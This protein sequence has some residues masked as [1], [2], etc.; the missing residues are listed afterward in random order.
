MAFVLAF[1]LERLCR[2]FGLQNLGFLTLTFEENLVSIREA[3]RRFHSLNAGVLRERYGRAIGVWERQGRGA[4]HFHLVVVIGGDVRTGVDFGAF[5]RRDYRTAGKVLRSEWAFWRRTA[6]RYGF[7]RH[8][9]YPIKST[10]WGIARYVGGYV[11]KHIDK[12]S[13]EDKGARVVRFIGFKPGT[14]RA[15]SRFAWNTVNGWLWRHK[16]KAFAAKLHVR[17][18][19]E[20]RRLFGPRWC[21]FWQGEIPAIMFN[22]RLIRYD[23]AAV[24][25]YIRN[26]MAG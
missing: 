20:L 3:Q 15:S 2:E 24:E 12:R 11:K 4:V 7:G 17:D 26:A 1:E 10:A 19:E 8:E 16:V 18:Y 22:R 25:E 9:L 6:K 21:Y 5:D 13:P 14:R 23:P